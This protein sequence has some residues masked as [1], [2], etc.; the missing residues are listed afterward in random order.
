MCV[1]VCVCVRLCV[2]VGVCN[3]SFVTFPMKYIFVPRMNPPGNSLFASQQW[4]ALTYTQRNSTE[5]Q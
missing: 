3:N 1:C 5:M 2:C 4:H